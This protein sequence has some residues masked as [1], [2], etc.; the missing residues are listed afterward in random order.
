MSFEDLDALL[1]SNGIH[2]QEMVDGIEN[3]QDALNGTSDVLANLKTQI[4]ETSDKLA[5][6]LSADGDEDF[7]ANPAYIQGLKDTLESL[8]L[9]YD[10][11]VSSFDF[12]SLYEEAT[13]GLEYMLE[14]SES[15]LNDFGKN[16]AGNEFF[17]GLLEEQIGQTIDAMNQMAYTIEE[18]NGKMKL[19]FRE[20]P[21]FSR[22]LENLWKSYLYIAEKDPTSGKIKEM[23]EQFSL[24]GYSIDDLVRKFGNFDDLLKDVKNDIE[25]FTVTLTYAYKLITGQFSQFE[26]DAKEIET[27][28]QNIGYFKL[29]LNTTDLDERMLFSLKNMQAFIATLDPNSEAWRDAD[30]IFRGLLDG[31]NSVGVS[32]D[33]IYEALGI[34]LPPI[35]VKI[36]PEMAEDFDPERLGSVSGS[37]K[38]PDIWKDDS[39]SVEYWESVLEGLDEAYYSKYNEIQESLSEAQADLEE[40]RAESALK[41]AKIDEEYSAK[42]KAKIADRT[43]IESSLY[44]MLGERAELTTS[45]RLQT[46]E[47][48][49]DANEIRS[50]LRIMGE[51]TDL[52]VLRD[53]EDAVARI[54]GETRDFTTGWDE[55]LSK[56]AGGKNEEF[57]KTTEAIGAASKALEDALYYGEDIDGTP[58]EDRINSLIWSAQNFANEL[59]PDSQAF[60]DAQAAIG[61]LTTK[62]YQAGGTMDKEA[63]AEAAKKWAEEMALAAEKQA[64]E[65]EEKGGFQLLKLDLDIAGIREQIDAVDEEISGLYEE[66]EQERIEVDL[67]ISK[68]E[69][70]VAKLRNDLRTLRN[71]W[72]SDK[73]YLWI[74]SGGAVGS[75]RRPTSVF[76]YADGG[77]IDSTQIALIHENEFVLS[78]DAVSALGKDKL[79][80]FNATADPRALAS[81]DRSTSVSRSSRAPERSPSFSVVVR[82]A[83]PATWVEITDKQIHPRVTT[84]ERKYKLGSNPYAR[85]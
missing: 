19:V 59:N 18:V 27:I 52:T 9:I 82:E 71:D 6:V 44:S 3:L 42:I 30:E 36:A 63:A 76:A 45:M 13:G 54:T 43:E 67:D 53:V 17:G 74:E 34:E 7:E 20:S 50:F 84:R 51:K 24:W 73:F 48:R 2:L 78:P 10:A 69:A 56:L 8:Q 80:S 39:G 5:W 70:N 77:Y 40:L 49:G 41:L 23:R 81:I 46:T 65:I 62:F 57:D 4:E 83:T 38:I 72:Y 37:V 32:W 31:L 64:A 26:S 75:D 11:Y 29:D 33:R 15:M 58:F 25:S 85:S 47:L 68:A 28:I 61:A 16:L 66:W 1:Q 79:E 14:L 60:K 35:K 22:S 55:M 21:A 12:V